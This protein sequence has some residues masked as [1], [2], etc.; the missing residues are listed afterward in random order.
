VRLAD[1]VTYFDR[2]PIAIAALTMNKDIGL[3][4][5]CTKLP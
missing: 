5:G 2:T 4:G 1:I 3:T